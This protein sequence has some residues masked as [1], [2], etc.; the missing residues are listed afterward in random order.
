MLR[1]LFHAGPA[2][3]AG[4]R[5]M[6]GVD[7]VEVGIE[8]PILLLELG[9]EVGGAEDTGLQQTDRKEGFS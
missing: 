2:V 3:D 9:V 5:L 4:S 8:P 6:V 1:A 7:L